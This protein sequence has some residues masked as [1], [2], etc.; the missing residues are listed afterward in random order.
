MPRPIQ[1]IGTGKQILLTYNKVQRYVLR[2]R[3]GHVETITL[4]ER[5]N[6]EK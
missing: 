6:V 2:P 3:T 5:K 4:L 1:K